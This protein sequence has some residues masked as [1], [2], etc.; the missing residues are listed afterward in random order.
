LS[1]AKRDRDTLPHGE[2]APDRPPF[3]SPR[4]TGVVVVGGVG[5]LVVLGSLSWMEIRQIRLGLDGRLE[6]ID[7][8]L[9]KVASRIERPAPAAQRGP[10]PNRVYTVKTDGAPARGPA[11]APVTIAEFS[12][13]Q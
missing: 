4:L 3:P 7:S 13:F 5:A 12:D 10:D 8:Q 9:E 11:G 1:K 2:T 6:R